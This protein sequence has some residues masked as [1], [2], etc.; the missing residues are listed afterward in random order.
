M[1]GMSDSFRM[2]Q[3][4]ADDVAAVAGDMQEQF[5]TAQL[6]LVGTSRGTAS[7]AYV[8]AAFGSRLSGVVLTSSVF[9]ASHGG[10][11]LSDFDYERIKVPLL[12]VHH[13]EDGCRVT[14]YYA[15]KALSEK[16]ALISVHGGKP[17]ASGSCDPVAPHGYYGVE[18]ATVDAIVRW[19]LGSPYPTQV[20]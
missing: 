13:I 10:A 9:D 2:S 7:A 19:M 11:G 15:A 8:G 14:P 4:H 20:E 3:L 18:S 1:R 5:P 17:A 16:Y 6:F 12:F